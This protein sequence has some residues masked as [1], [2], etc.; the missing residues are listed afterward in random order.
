MKKTETVQEVKTL[1]NLPD[2]RVKESPI[3]IVQDI[4]QYRRKRVN[5]LH[6]R[7]YTD[8]KI[9]D[10]IDCSISTV[11]KDLKAIR[12]NY[13]KWFEEE[14]K[15]DFCQSVSDAITVYENGIEDLQILYPEAVEINEKLQILNTISDF[16]IKKIDI[17]RKT[18]AVQ[19]FLRRN[20]K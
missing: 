7:G 20:R 5:Q 4:I 17:Y 14:A 11:E 19:N 9:A 6:L 10:E 13:R 16:E 3:S 1:S 8:K 12:E 18:P 15:T 2:V